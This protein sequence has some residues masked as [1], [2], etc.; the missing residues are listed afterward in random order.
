MTLT[1]VTTTRDRPLCFGILEGIIS[2]QTLQPDQWLVVNDGLEPYSYRRGQEVVRRRPKKTMKRA[3]GKKVDEISILANWQTAFPKIKGE[4]V[5]VVEDDDWYHPAY[6]ETVSK[7][8]DEY[9]VV[10]VANDYYFKLASRRYKMMYNLN[11]ASLAATAFRSSALF[12]VQRAVNVLAV[13]NRSVFVDMYLWAEAEGMHGLKVKLVPNRATDGRAY[14]VGMKQMPGAAGLGQGHT[15]QGT[16]DPAWSQLTAWIG[17][18]ACRLYRS[19]P[20]TA[21]GRT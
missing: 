5:A 6:L 9:D 4:K 12:A 16:P 13:N 21:W 15:D 3:D 2:R 11:H 20:K 8:L 10:G 7:L 18:E 19:I 1:I 14:H 17:P